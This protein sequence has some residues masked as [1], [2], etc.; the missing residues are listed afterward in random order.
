M[1][2]SKYVSATAQADTTA[3]PV[4]ITT[5]HDAVW[6]GGSTSED[7]LICTLKDDSVAVT[8]GNVGKGCFLPI[9]LSNVTTCVDLV[10]LE[11]GERWS[12]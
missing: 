4:A 9:Q 3:T 2:Y 12:N 10:L 8:F 11:S 5:D 6:H 1:A 7:D